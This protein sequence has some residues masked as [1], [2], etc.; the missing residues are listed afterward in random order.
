MWQQFA[1]DAREEEEGE[2]ENKK[3]GGMESRHIANIQRER[4][5]WFSCRTKWS[6]LY[7]HRLFIRSPVHKPFRKEKK[8]YIYR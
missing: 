3:K 6:V 7:D 5:K 1:Q 2:E 4:E 8:I